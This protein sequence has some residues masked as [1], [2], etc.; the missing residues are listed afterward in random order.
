M[1]CDLYVT[2]YLVVLGID[3]SDF[4][5]VFS[6]VFATINAA[7]FVHAMFLSSSI[8]DTRIRT[9][10]VADLRFNLKF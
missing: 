4:S 8:V 5:V 3:D 10:S 6:S 9:V 1:S 2:D 7:T